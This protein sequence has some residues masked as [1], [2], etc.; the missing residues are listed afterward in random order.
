[1]KY[2][3][4]IVRHF[5]PRRRWKEISVIRI[6]D[7]EGSGRPTNHVFILQDQFGNRKKFKT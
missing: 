7:S 2:L 3:F 5:F 6:Y 1:M 4:M